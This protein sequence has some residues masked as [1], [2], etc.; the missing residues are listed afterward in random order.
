MHQFTKVVQNDIISAPFF[1]VSSL[2]FDNLFV[3]DA[4]NEG[5]YNIASNRPHQFMS[6][7]GV[8]NNGTSLSDMRSLKQLIG[9]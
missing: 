5:V 4:H 6:N 7:F 2:G 8:L 9:A 1:N 3:S